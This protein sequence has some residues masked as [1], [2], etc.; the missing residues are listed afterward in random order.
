[1][2]VGSLPDT[3]AGRLG[4]ALGA[5][6]LPAAAAAGARS[7]VGRN[8]NWVVVLPDGTQVFVKVYAHLGLDGAARFG[9]AALL[10][11]RYGPD[12]PVRR[13]RCLAIAEEPMAMA[14]EH[15][16]A[17]RS[18][19]ELAAA[20]EFDTATA[21]WVGTQLAALHGARLPGLDHTPPR[22]PAP[23]S[24]HA[25]TVQDVLRFSAGE[26][27]A[28]RLL[29]SDPG[30][31]DGLTRLRALEAAHP[32]VPVHGDLRLDQ[33]LVA[34]GRPHLN[35]WEDLRAADPAR[36]LGTFAGEWLH[37]AALALLPGPAARV[38]GEPEPA[39]LAGSHR[40]ILARGARELAARRP[41]VEALLAGYRDRGA[42]Y[43]PDT[44]ERAAMFAGWHLID[45]LLAGASERARL[46]ALE[47]AAAGIGRSAVLDPAAAVPALGLAP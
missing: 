1:M 44:A 31:I 32:P 22:R 7:R 47:R 12:E 23:D 8:E 10:E 40:E 29:Q 34:G 24:L 11:R 43:D 42:P 26:I 38:A 14:F 20:G 17:V 18:G 16:D 21:Y 28:W 2:P 13:P 3:A 6:G 45:R 15:L 46:G 37:R 4:A 30:L 36:D 33:I 19:A 27:Q 5:L 9:R 39:D 25:L 41:Y 35:D